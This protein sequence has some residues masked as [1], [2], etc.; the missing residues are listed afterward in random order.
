QAFQLAGF[1]GEAEQVG[2]CA[3]WLFMGGFYGHV[4]LLAVIDHLFSTTKGVEKLLISPG[5]VYLV[6]WFQH[7][8]DELETYL[9]VAAAGG[10]VAENF[11]PALTHYV[12]D[13]AGGHMAGYAGGVPIITFIAGLG[14]NDF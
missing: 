8:G 14:L 7:V 1:V 13:Q 11:D 12:Q 6:V 4:A 3:V 10:T 9:V 5:G 2:V